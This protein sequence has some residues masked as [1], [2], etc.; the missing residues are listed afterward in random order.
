MRNDVN[1]YLRKLANEERKRNDYIN[2]SEKRVEKIEE[3]AIEAAR[4]KYNNIYLVRLKQ[5]IEKS[6]KEFEKNEMDELIRRV[7]SEE[8][9]IEIIKRINV[10][11]IIYGK[12]IIDEE[13]EGFLDRMFEER[14]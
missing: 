4:K 9:T 13:N 2:A 11:D 8:L 6:G 10:K 5:E 12:D 7:N 14:A 3:K 1:K